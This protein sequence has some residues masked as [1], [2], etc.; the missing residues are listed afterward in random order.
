MPIPEL[1]ANGHLPVGVFDCTLSE[2]RQRFG[3]FQESDRRPLLFARLKDLAA[4]MHRS[5]LFEAILLD[6]SFVTA[7]SVPNDIDLIAVLPPDYH[8]EQDLK[9]AD[10]A[11]VSRSLLKRRFG[12]DVILARRDSP[13][14][15][16]MVEF[17]SRVRESQRWRKGLLRVPL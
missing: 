14:Y 3:G 2:V 17:F 5:G 8:F 16:K 13:L 9:M 10:Y 1:D 11:L 12:F 7:K 4:A 6:G 15:H